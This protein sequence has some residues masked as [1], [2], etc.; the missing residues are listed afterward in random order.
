MKPIAPNVFDAAVIGAGPAGATAARLLARWGHSVAMIGRAPARRTLGE[1]LPPSCTKLF[2]TLGIRDAVDA[3]SFVRATGN[4]VQWGSGA[5]R[6]ERFAS[7]V[8]G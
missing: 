7:G 3:G 4:T 1:S 6:V 5:A 2:D 8:A